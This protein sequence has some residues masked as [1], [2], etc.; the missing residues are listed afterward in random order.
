MMAG[1]TGPVWESRPLAV[2]GHILRTEGVGGLYRGFVAGAICW[3]V[4][5]CTMFPVF[6]AIRPRILLGLSPTGE[7]A[8]DRHVPLGLRF[9]ADAS[10][11]MI[12]GAVGASASAPLDMLRTRLQALPAVRPTRG[13]SGASGVSGILQ[14]SLASMPQLM[15]SRLW[16]VLWHGTCRRVVWCAPSCA[17]SLGTFETVHHLLN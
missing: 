17:I 6:E 4:M 8:P 2:V 13:V 5:A 16:S 9:C 10:A 12:A 7:Q 11:G 3:G 1:I 14:R 15:D